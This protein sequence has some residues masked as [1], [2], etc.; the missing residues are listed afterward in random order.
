MIAH[1]LSE[2][3]VGNMPFTPT[4]SQLSAIDIFTH[5][6]ADPS[7][8]SVFVLSGYAGTGKTSLVSSIVQTLSISGIAICLM[9]P[10]GRAAK[11]LSTRAKRDAYTIH[12]IIYKSSAAMLE[13]GGSFS[14]VKEG[15]SGSLY[16]VDEA[17]MIGQEGSNSGLFGSGDLLTDL[18]AYV[19][20]TDTAKLILV[21]DTAQLPPVGSNISPA[22]DTNLLTDLYG[23]HIYSASLTDVI[24]QKQESGILAN[25][26][27]LRDLLDNGEQILLHNCYADTHFIGGA[28]LIES[29]DSAYRRYGREDVLVVCYSN[30]RALAYN[31]GIRAQVLDLEEELVRGDRLVVVRNNYAYAQNRD[32]TDFLANGEIVEIRRLGKYHELYEKRFVE[33]DIYLEDRDSELTVMLLLDTLATESAHMTQGE[34]EAFYQNVLAD[35]QEEAS[36]V[37]CRELVRKNPYWQALEVKYAYALTCHKAQGGQWPCIFIDMGLVSLMERDNSLLRWL[38]TALTRA[39]QEVFFVNTPESMISHS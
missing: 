30:K 36:V 26:T 10:T 8:Y 1:S 3:I 14:L 5:F 12:R 4:V 33:A 37:K 11:I 29:I 31:L 19:I 13:E 22:L 15:R 16:V 9:A 35:Y 23:L 32:K 27:L 7:P 25:A 2:Q 17:S 34:R 38:Y 6:L 20:G 21:G 28:E 39:T 18:L 24:R